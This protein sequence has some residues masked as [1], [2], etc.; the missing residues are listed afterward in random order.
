[1][2]LMSIALTGFI[3]GLV[4]FAAVGAQTLFLL[5]QGAR[6]VRML[7]LLA[8]GAASDVILILLGVLGTGALIRAFPAATTV[9]TVVGVLF[10]LGYGAVSLR[11]A[12]TSGA[13]AQSDAQ[14]REILDLDVED[15][16]QGGAAH[17]SGAAR[18]G[19]AE[20]PRHSGARRASGGRAST[21]VLER[22]VA[23][24]V[25]PA[26][27][28]AASRRPPLTR[29]I[30]LGLLAFTWLNPQVYLDVVVVLGSMSANYPGVGTW[31]FTAGVMA[32]SVAWF[33]ILGVASKGMGRVLVRYPRAWKALDLV[34]GVLMIVLA[35]VLATHLL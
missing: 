14:A 29:G 18:G 21:D 1:M 10:L 33:A 3:S 30:V 19:A 28:G 20:A 17:G 6:G 16:E 26:A 9:L 32:A 22:A 11:K 12:F 23:P 24:A 15:E 4:L 13:G 25:A 31:V 27:S 8:L 5:K 35:G 2:Q 7:P 34:T